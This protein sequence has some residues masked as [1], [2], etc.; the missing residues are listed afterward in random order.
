LENKKNYSTNSCA[1]NEVYIFAKRFSEL[2]ADKRKEVIECLAHL[3]N[4]DSQ[5][6]EPSSPSE[7]H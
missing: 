2:S 6:S 3:E 4:Q 1:D 5:S 7:D